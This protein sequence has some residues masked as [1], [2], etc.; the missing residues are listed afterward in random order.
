MGVKNYRLGNP[1]LQKGKITLL[2]M[3]NKGRSMGK[4]FQLFGCL[5]FRKI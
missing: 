4:R 5:V 2:G 1:E 3:Y